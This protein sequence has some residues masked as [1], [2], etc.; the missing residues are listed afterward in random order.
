MKKF[1]RPTYIVIFFLLVSFT[2]YYGYQ[3]DKYTISD[4]SKYLETLDTSDG[5]GA[6]GPS[7]EGTKSG[8]LTDNNDPAL[9]EKHKIE[10]QVNELLKKKL[11][12]ELQYEREQLDA[13]VK[14]Y[15]EESR[16]LRREQKSYERKKQKLLDDAQKPV[17]VNIRERNS[18]NP[19]FV[20]KTYTF[21][22]NN[23][24]NP[25]DNIDGE[26]N[27]LVILSAVTQQIDSKDG[28]FNN[29]LALLEGLDYPNSKT[30]LSILLSSKDEFK[31]FDEYVAKIFKEIENTKDLESL[32]NSFSKITLMNAQFIEDEFKIDRANRQKP[33]AQKQ[34]RKLLA[35]LRNFLVFN[36]I[37]AE[38]YSLSVDSDMIELPKDLITTFIESGKDIVTIRV[39][40]KN[41]AG[42][43]VHKDFD[44]NSWA[45]DRKTPTPEQDADPNLFFEPG[46]GPNKIQFS[47]IHKNPSKYGLKRSDKKSLFELNSVGGAVLFV[48]TEIFKQGIMF[49]PYYAVG[50]KW[51]REDGF[52]GIETEG[53]CYQAKSIGYSCWGLPFVV[54]YHEAS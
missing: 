27:D 30:S 34:R 15:N 11:E 21:K 43:V 4:I 53:L 10:N 54:G 19:S 6:N 24:E 46:P 12:S 42:H 17:E 44:L 7:N 3:Q 20:Q 16:Q 29:F 5:K 32:K 41:S 23:K 48:K 1:S 38:I 51:D 2:I 39:D 22:T 45:G 52:D 37:G 50:T 28:K 26:K 8:K 35:R 33:E 13:E 9:I 18:E 49:P 40:M 36:G 14:K 25:N 31:K 47:D